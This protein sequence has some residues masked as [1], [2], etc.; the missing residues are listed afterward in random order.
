MRKSYIFMMLYRGAF[1]GIV[2]LFATLSAH[3]QGNLKVAWGLHAK[4]FNSPNFNQVDSVI[5]QVNSLGST[6]SSQLSVEY[7][8]RISDKVRLNFRIMSHTRLFSFRARNQEDM[9]MGIP[10]YKG[11]AVRGLTIQPAVGL[12]LTG[13][14]L[15]VHGGLALDINNMANGPHVPFN[16][17]SGSPIGDEQIEL[18]INELPKTV[19][20]FALHYRVG[21]SR[22]IGRFYLSATYA[23]SMTNILREFEIE[24]QRTGLSLQTAF[25]FVEVGF[26]LWKADKTDR[27]NGKKNINN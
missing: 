9:V 1:P 22:D 3:S 27:E 11:K 26:Y 20:P 10:L 7:E 23:R 4:G 25:V 6:F 19:R 21:I 18:V 2:F 14:Y 16:N 5:Y 15:N 24:G 8:P 13:R 17:K 12:N